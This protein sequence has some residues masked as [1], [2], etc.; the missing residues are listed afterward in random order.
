MSGY[1]FSHTVSVVTGNGFS[2]WV[3]LWLQPQPGLLAPLPSAEPRLRSRFVILSG[4][5]PLSGAA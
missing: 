2:R 5:V 3:R 4:A 1:D